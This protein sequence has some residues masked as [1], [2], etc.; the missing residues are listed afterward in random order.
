MAL[1]NRHR[2]CIEIVAVVLFIAIMIFLGELLFRDMPTRIDY[3]YANIHHSND[4]I[5]LAIVGNS[6][7]GAIGKIDVFD[8]GKERVGNY[9]VSGQDLFHAK[10][11]VDE[12]I[13]SKKNL[14]YIIL[15]VDYD[16]LG[17]NLIETNQRYTDREYYKYADTMQ[18]MSLENKL[19]ARSNFFRC[20]RAFHLVWDK[21]FSNNSASDDTIF[22]QEETFIPVATSD[23]KDDA[24]RHRAEEITSI[25]FKS[26]LIAEN[27]L[28]LQRII[29]KITVQ[30]IQLVILVPPKRSCFYCYADSGNSFLAKNKLYQ[31]IDSNNKVCFIDLY[32]NNSFVDD[33][34][35]DAD[36]LNKEGA[37]KV[38]QLIM[39]EYEKYV[40]KNK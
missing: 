25:K 22:A 34:F 7:A 20:N 29:H 18:D 14:K 11:I 6:H 36:H 2:F 35:V 16:M 8:V 30:K 38:E 33:D 39:E 15:F 10:L 4:T 24:C 40:A 26:R 13:K 21:Y 17:Y 32:G 1:N 27:G 12:L 9:S 28:V 5:E 23:N 19:M 31:M 3:L 37:K